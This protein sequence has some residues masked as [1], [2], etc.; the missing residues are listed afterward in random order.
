MA[1]EREFSILSAVAAL[2]SLDLQD[3]KVAACCSYLQTSTSIGYTLCYH[4]LFKCPMTKSFLFHDSMHMNMVSILN[5]NISAESSLPSSTPVNFC[6]ISEIYHSFGCGD[7]W[8]KLPGSGTTPRCHLLPD[9]LQTPRRSFSMTKG[10][11]YVMYAILY[12]A[13][14]SI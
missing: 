12:V 10:S 6:V 14:H 3:T 11:L 1:L 13:T 5:V 2:P 4:A 7:F 9:T 8:L